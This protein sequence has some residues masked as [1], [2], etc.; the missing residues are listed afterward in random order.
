M[1]NVTHIIEALLKANSAL[2]LPF[3]FCLSL[4]TK[5]PSVNTNEVKIRYK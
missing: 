5:W 1:S 2:C 4:W 3:F